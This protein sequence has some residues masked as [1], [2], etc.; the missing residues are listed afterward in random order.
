MSL[1]RKEFLSS[2]VSAVAG[3]AGAA[4]LVACGGGSESE[5]HDARVGGNCLASGTSAAIGTNHGH[6][7]TVPMAD[8]T[9]GVEKTYDIRGTSDHPHTVKVTAA[10]FASLASNSGVSVLSSSDGGHTHNVT[11]SC[12]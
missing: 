6:T 12:N 10:M 4:L 1:T 3:A 2:M 11:I 9:A 8:V 5:M 7:L